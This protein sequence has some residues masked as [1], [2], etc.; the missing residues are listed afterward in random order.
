MFAQL[1]KKSTILVVDDFPDNLLIFEEILQEE[2]YKIVL[3]QNGNQALQFI[4]EILPDLI[5]LDIMM[6]EMDGFEITKSIRQNPIL[7]FIPILLITAHDG[8]SVVEGL[9]LGADDFV[10]K[11][12]E[13]DELLARVRCLLRL[14][15]SIDEKDKIACIRE[16]FVSRL[17][18]DLRIPLIAADRMLMLMQNGMLGELE[19]P[20][21]EAL[22]VMMKSNKNLLDMVNTLLEVYRYESANKV[23]S[24]TQVNL[25]NIIINIIEELKPL[26]IEKKIELNYVF[27]QENSR[28]PILQGDTLEL[29]RAFTNLI[30][31]AI[32][33]TEKGKIEIKLNFIVDKNRENW[34]LFT[35]KDTGP[36]ISLEQ[37]KNLFNRFSPGKHRRSGS[38]LGLHL[39]RQI[40]EKHQGNISVRSKV[41]EGSLFLV[42]LPMNF[43]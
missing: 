6:P 35:V 20:V 33:F 13:I 31:N 26:A 3:A 7:P 29:R 17:A 14:K 10:R 1:Y 27:T 12:V 15:Q 34:I 18:H 39:S 40:I 9:D 8:P 21:Q 24:F 22:T 5:L 23:L 16:D 38:G 43:S 32:K 25:D 42:T 36:G 19:S 37:Q 11:P 28:K 41:G 4:P 2:G 30:G